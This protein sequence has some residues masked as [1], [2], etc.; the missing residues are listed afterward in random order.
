MSPTFLKTEADIIKTV[1]CGPIW[2]PGQSRNWASQSVK[3]LWVERI[4]G[5]TIWVLKLGRWKPGTLFRWQLETWKNFISLMCYTSYQCQTLHCVHTACGKCENPKQAGCRWPG[6]PRAKDLHLDRG[7]CRLF[8]FVAVAQASSRL[9]VTAGRTG[10][11]Q[12]VH[13]LFPCTFFPE[14]PPSL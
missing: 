1:S 14:F 12:R 13:L 2:W 6:H 5:Y 8:L 3:P 10:E 7:E 9:V 4:A 11:T